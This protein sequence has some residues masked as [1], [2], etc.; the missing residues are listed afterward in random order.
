M[1]QYLHVGYE[2]IRITLVASRP[3]LSSMMTTT[4]IIMT[5]D[6]GQNM[7]SWLVWHLYQTHG[8]SD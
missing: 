8:S 6:Q 2:I 7:V 3:V 5:F 4:A 1:F